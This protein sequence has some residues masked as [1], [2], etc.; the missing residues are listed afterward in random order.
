VACTARRKVEGAL[1]FAAV[2]LQAI[3]EIHLPN[4]KYE[5]IQIGNRKYDIMA[6]A[7]D[8]AYTMTGVFKPISLNFEN[9]VLSPIARKVNEKNIVLIGSVPY[10]TIGVTAFAPAATG[11]YVKAMADNIILVIRY[12]KMNFGNLYHNTLGVTFVCACFLT[13]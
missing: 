4:R 7:R 1:Y 8:I 3:L 6:I 13:L 5:I 10:V 12:P 9:L 11:G 2:K